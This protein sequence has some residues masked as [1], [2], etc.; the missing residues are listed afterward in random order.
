MLDREINEINHIENWQDKLVNSI[1]G[2]GSARAFLLITD[3]KNHNVALDSI[4]QKVLPNTTYY[5]SNVMWI[6]GREEKIN[7]ESIRS[8][9][10][11]LNK[12]SY[13][14]LPRVIVIENVDGLNLHSGNAL[15]K[16]LE[17]CNVD[18]YFVLLCAN[19]N[20]VIPTIRSRCVR[21]IL[22]RN[23][24]DSEI[25]CDFENDFS[26]VILK[27]NDD[28][29]VKYEFLDSYF[30]KDSSENKW[31]EFSLC[32]YKLLDKIVKEQGSQLDEKSIDNF[33]SIY[34]LVSSAD[35]CNLSFYN[36]ALLI[37]QKLKDK[38]DK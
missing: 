24:S 6:G 30:S 11:F 12:T 1:S 8:I 15:L 32:I 17:D 3:N 20:L 28:V 22:P 34:S 27:Q 35:K 7:T 5:Q 2:K 21:M 13:N 16:I 29:R 33:K 26:N 10:G 4:L 31:A 36:S 14:K 19:M 9:Y 37:L 25:N 23:S 38:N 18:A